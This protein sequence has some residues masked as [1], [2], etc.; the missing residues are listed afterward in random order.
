MYNFSSVALENLLDGTGYSHSMS[1]HHSY[2]LYIRN[3]QTI[4]SEAPH[5]I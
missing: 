5:N 4:L 1:L 3:V 2:V